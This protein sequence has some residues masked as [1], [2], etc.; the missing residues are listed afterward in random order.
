MSDQTPHD[1]PDV[2]LRVLSSVEALPSQATGAL[3]F[4]TESRITGVVLL[5]SGRVCWAAASGLRKRL[6]DLLR[7][8]SHRELTAEEVEQLFVTCKEQ[9]KPL[10]EAFLERGWLSSAA[11]RSA[12]LH[13]TAESLSVAPS[14]LSSPRWVPHRTCGYSSAF[15][16][17]PAE[18]LAFASAAAQGEA[19]AHSAHDRLRELAGDRNSALF[20]KPGEVLLAC[21]LPEQTTTGLCELRQAGAWAAMSLGDSNTCSE[22]SIKF[23]MDGRGGSWVGWR[24]AGLTYLVH[25]QNREDFSALARSL[26]HHGWTS[27]VFSSVPLPTA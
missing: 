22:A 1:G 14:W 9:H 21:Q 15:T 24:D 4:G 11:L 25:C 26:N 2:A 13:H 7:A 10:G 16:F 12:L 6:S 5:E 20:D 8:A 19:M 23:A 3:I 18:L 17:L 27:M